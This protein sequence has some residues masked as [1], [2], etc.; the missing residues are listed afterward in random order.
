[1][2]NEAKWLNVLSHMS[3]TV[4][5][6]ISHAQKFMPFTIR[7]SSRFDEKQFVFKYI[8]YKAKCWH[9]AS[10]SLELDLLQLVKNVT[11]VVFWGH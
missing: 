1:M 7:F 4:L 9:Y 6:S 10:L 11:D 8:L 5:P 2:R 3:Y